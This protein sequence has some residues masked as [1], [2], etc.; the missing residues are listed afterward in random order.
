MAR[1][2]SL[3]PSDLAVALYLALYPGARYESIAR[4]LGIGVASAHRSVARLEASGL[5]LPSFREPD[6][7]ALMGFLRHGVRH[8]FFA[9]PGGETPGVPTA[10]SA[11]PLSA[12][13]V[14][15][16][17][18]VWPSAHGSARGSA[19]TPLFSGAVDLPVRDPELY[20]I[21][22]L[23]DAL[24]M[25]GARERAMAAD[26]LETR[27]G[28]PLGATPPAGAN[29]RAANTP[30]SSF[31]D[32]ITPILERHRVARAGV[33]GSYARGEA[34]AESDLDLLVELPHGSS[35]LDL[36]AIQLE[37]SA[38]LGLDVDVNTYRA[39]HPL[40]RDRILAE[41]VRIL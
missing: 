38:A 18:V 9:R 34:S 12:T 10:H 29:D 6:R 28:S 25:G 13:I 2:E 33:F 41:E 22:T 37:L 36:V 11:P 4:G 15:E 21:L 7:P 39:I 17:P 30:V 24:R 5:L 1:P 23:V 8:A 32:R 19:V 35:L 26:L 3:N 27:L 14:S 16:R 31:T 40:L 20:G